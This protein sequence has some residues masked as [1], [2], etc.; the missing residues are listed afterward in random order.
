M[1]PFYFFFCWHVSNVIKLN[2]IILQ[3]LSKALVQVQQVANHINGIV[4]ERQN[5]EKILTIQ[6]SIKIPTG[7]PV[8]MA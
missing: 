7:S 3:E 6:K 2:A 4:K 1:T 8:V 5:L